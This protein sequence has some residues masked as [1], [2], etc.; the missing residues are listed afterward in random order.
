MKIEN[1]HFTS[2]CAKNNKPTEYLNISERQLGIYRS[3]K[4]IQK[5]V[6]GKIVKLKIA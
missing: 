2:T 4:R 6:G 3:N 5:T 1:L